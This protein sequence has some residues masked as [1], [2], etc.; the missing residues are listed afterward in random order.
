MLGES[1][2]EAAPRLN[3]GHVL[4]E[5]PLGSAKVAPAGS[6]PGYPF[7]WAGWRTLWPGWPGWFWCR[8][9]PFTC[10][11]RAG[12]FYVLEQHRPTL[13][14][15]GC[16]CLGEHPRAVNARMADKIARVEDAASP[17]GVLA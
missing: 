4:G 2:Y 17:P 8:E 15:A 7:A 12:G 16:A 9:Y 1:P 14:P 5:L 10:D 3:A 11:P 6:S 13:A